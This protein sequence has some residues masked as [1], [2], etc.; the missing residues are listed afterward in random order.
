MCWNYTEPAVSQFWE[1]RGAGSYFTGL[2]CLLA[3]ISS[4]Q[5]G[6]CCLRPHATGARLHWQAARFQPSALGAAAAVLMLLFLNEGPRCCQALTHNSSFPF[7]SSKGWKSVSSTV[8][9]HKYRSLGFFFCFFFWGVW[10]I[11]LF[12]WL[13]QW[14]VYT[15]LM[16]LPKVF[17]WSFVKSETGWYTAQVKKH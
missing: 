1:R 12:A 7:F 14:Q 3:V 10:V 15:S 2:F 4:C 17:H 8:S 16:R 5:F 11:L 9:E 6:N 13:L